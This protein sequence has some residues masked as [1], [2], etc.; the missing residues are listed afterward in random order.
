MAEVDEPII[1]GALYEDDHG[2]PIRVRSVWLDENLTTQVTVE[3]EETD[4]V[5][6]ERETIPRRQFV[7]EINHSLFRV[8]SDHDAW[9]WRER[10]SQ[11]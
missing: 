9:E 7:E 4:V 8:N 11:R 5:G 10:V 6:Q 1:R 2:E 3:L